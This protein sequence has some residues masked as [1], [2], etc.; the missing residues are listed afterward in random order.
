MDLK[1]QNILLGDDMEP[2]I[3]EFG[4]LRFLDQEVLR[5]NTQ[6]VVGT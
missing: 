4:I 3:A 2:K 6:D 5:L 1:P